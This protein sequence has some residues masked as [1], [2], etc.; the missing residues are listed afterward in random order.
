MGTRS[1][2]IDPSIIKFMADES[3]RGLDDITND[4]NKNSGLKGISGVNDF[5][6]LM[7]MIDDGNGLAKLAYDVFM[8]SIIKYIAEYYFE[9]DGNV[10]AMVFTAGILENNV[11]IREDILD[12]IE[13]VLVDNYMDIYNNLRR[14]E[15]GS[16]KGSKST[17]RN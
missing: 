17:K 16:K 8:D 13:F 14:K 9:L 3:G 6:D 2:S 1:G 11:R 7:K 5:R 10:D 12:K 4:L 15:S